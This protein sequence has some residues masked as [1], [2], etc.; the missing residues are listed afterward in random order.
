MDSVVV[1]ETWAWLQ[2]HYI[3]AA[4][5]KSSLLFPY[6]VADAAKLINVTPTE[7][8]EALVKIKA[9]RG[10]APPT[11]YLVKGK[12]YFFQADLDDFNS[13]KTETTLTM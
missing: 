1:T 11:E 7:L 10:V 3:R 6:E 13:R 4:K 9:L 8:K 5:E 12:Y 2:G